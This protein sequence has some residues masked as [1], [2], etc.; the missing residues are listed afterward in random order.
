[1]SR[2]NEESKKVMAVIGY[3]VKL[4]RK[5]KDLNQQELAD[6][7]GITRVSVSNIEKGRHMLTID[8]AI[9]IC[10]YFNV[11]YLDIFPDPV[12]YNM[13]FETIDAAIQVRQNKERQIAE[14]KADFLKRVKEIQNN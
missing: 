6:L 5:G 9:K 13:A 2:I 14:A 7:L 12:M 8:N 1:V 10:K 11:T 4:L 3:N